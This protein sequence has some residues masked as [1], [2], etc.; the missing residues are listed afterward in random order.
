MNRLLI[1]SIAVCLFGLFTQTASAQNM[2]L[3][4]C[5]NYAVLNQSKVKSSYLDEK[6]QL[7]KN[8]QLGSAVYPTI[9]ATGGIQQFLLVPKS[10]SRADLFSF[11]N[12]YAP[13]DSSVVNYAAI[14]EAAK[15]APEYTTLQF[16]LPVNASAT[17]QIQQIIFNSD[18]LVAL[19]ARKTIEELTQLNTKRTIEQIKV[20]V[21]KAYYNCIISKKRVALLDENIRLL[22]EFERN[23]KG[24]FKEGFV[25]RIDVDKLTVQKNNLTT[26]QSKI[27]NLIE[28]GEQLL[29][30]QMG[31]ELDNQIT[32]T[33]DLDINALELDGLLLEEL[34]IS[35]RTEYQLLGKVKKLNEYNLTRTQKSNLPTVAAFGNFGMA[36][37]GKRLP[38]LFTLAWFP[39]SLVGINASIGLFDGGKRKHT[40]EELKYTI[41]KTVIDE[42]NLA[43]GVALETQSART[44]LNNSIKSLNTQ[45]ANM[46]LAEKVYDIAQRKSKEG[47]GT[48]V[49]VLQAQ[50]ALK[51]SQTNY[52][53]ALYDA[54]IAKID[55]QKALGTYKITE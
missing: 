13:I 38:E 52:L 18:V 14:A 9:S 2:S 34:N 25:E 19:Q 23:M 39:S 50:T 35:N 5:I 43:Q 40:L 41:Q 20:D 21:S 1:V 24:M 55:L 46:A 36:T 11:G 15:N 48:T 32:L 16:G 26:E 51:E 17:L 7:A 53:G 27:N 4:D 10:R 28:L 42:D 44:T 54:T 33:D 31:M 47:V 45:K 22:G 30:F 6:I 29:K 37:A 12:L 3:T 49:E 8:K